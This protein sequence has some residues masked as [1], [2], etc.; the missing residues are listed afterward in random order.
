MPWHQ[1]VE[2]GLRH[3]SGRTPRALSF[4]SRRLACYQTLKEISNRQLQHGRNIEETACRYPID[5]SLIFL[6]LLECDPQPLGKYL[7]AHFSLQASLPKAP[8]NVAVHIPSRSRPLFATHVLLFNSDHAPTIHQRGRSLRLIMLN[9]ILN[10]DVQ[11]DR[12]YGKRNKPLSPS[13]SA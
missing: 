4:R 7:L 3:L 12:V 9:L 10:C 2:K 8:A 1:C 5:A 6:D 13:H 11:P